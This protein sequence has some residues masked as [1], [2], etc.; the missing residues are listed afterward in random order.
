MWRQASGHDFSRAANQ[1]S[2]WA[3]APAGIATESAPSRNDSLVPAPSEGSLI[4][5][6]QFGGYTT[7]TAVNHRLNWTIGTFSAFAVSNS[8]SFTISPIVFALNS[9]GKIAISR[10]ID[11]PQL[12]RSRKG[13]AIW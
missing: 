5:N 13:S 12:H 6:F 8:L 11:V 9:S 3:L 4:S 10:A 7:G 1:K 2:T